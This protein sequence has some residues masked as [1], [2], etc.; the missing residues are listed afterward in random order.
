MEKK[1]TVITPTI[2][3]PS[4]A[5]TCQ[6]LDRQ[7][8]ERWQHLVVVD[9]PPQEILPAQRDLLESLQHPN[10]TILF[11]ET[12]HRNFGNRCRHEAFGHVVG[13]YLLYLDDDDEYVGEV[14][15][16]LNREISEEVWGVFPV[17][18]FGHIFFNVPPA[19]CHTTSNQ[20]FYRPLYPWP[21]NDSYMADGELVELLCARHPDYLVVNSEPLARVT[22]Q[23]MGKL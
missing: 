2:L 15:A 14:F 19:I 23:G 6:S 16:V 12:A 9:V 17:E 10:R 18:R 8:Y 4:L 1:F 20:F 21:D 11:C 5:E 22:R 13:D 3:R 7:S